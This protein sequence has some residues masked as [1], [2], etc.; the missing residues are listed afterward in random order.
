MNWTG[1]K[2]Q[3]KALR[4][5][6]LCVLTFLLP[7]LAGIAVNL[8]GDM[9]FSAVAEPSF[10][11]IRNGLTVEMEDWLRTNGTVEI[12][13]SR[14]ELEEAVKEPATQT[15]GVLAKDGEMKTIRSGDELTMY[16]KIT[17]RLPRLYEQRELT[18]QYDLKVLP[19]GG[20]SDI[21]KPLLI[22][23]VMVTAMF[24][25]CT[26][27]AMNILSEKEDGIEYVN[28]IL[29]MTRGQYVRQKIAVGFVGGTVSTVITALICMRIAAAQILPLLLL[30]VL[31]AFVAALAGLFIARVSGGLMVGI[32]YIKIIMILF[33]APPILF[34]MLVPADSV[35]YG[36]SY[37]F[38][39]G[40][41]FYG[42]MGLMD[43]RTDM[44][45]E[46]AALAGHGAVWS[47][48]Y[49]MMGRRHREK[50]QEG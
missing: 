39:S 11:I 38:P 34:Y 23:I 30:V 41:T 19:A 6:K 26:F 9:D 45:R 12:Y 3:L 46:V 21:M 22:V 50:V 47:A 49:V 37:L 27:N 31:S 44:V 14:E 4:R 1:L 28:E 48:V 10:G 33:L 7:I 35:W 25:G 29:P 13:D 20:G 43:G 42:L 16:A 40:A 15:V 18:A 36:G 17:D 32:V 2:Y 24:M 5:D 8:M